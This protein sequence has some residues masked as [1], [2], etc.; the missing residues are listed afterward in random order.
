MDIENNQPTKNAVRPL[1]NPSTLHKMTEDARL[2]YE[3]V[4]ALL[5]EFMQQQVM[6]RYQVTVKSGISAGTLNPWLDGTTK[7]NYANTTKAVRDFLTSMDDKSAVEEAA[8]GEFKKP[9]FIETQISKR[10]L[11]ALAYAQNTPSM[12]SVTIGT[13]MGKTTTAKHFCSTRAN[14]LYVPISPDTCAAYALRRELI[15]AAGLH[16]T[17]MKS[18]IKT[19]GEHMSQGDRR[20][21]IIIDEAQYLPE[22]SINS[23][24]YLYDVYGIGLAFIGNQDIGKKLALSSSTQGVGQIQSRFGLRLNML[25]PDQADIDSYLDAW[26]II[27]P[28]MRSIFTVLAGKT[29]AFR[30]VD[31]TLQQAVTQAAG[32]KTPLTA[33]IVRNAWRNRSN[34]T[35]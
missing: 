23:L 15:D 20:S 22:K 13:G 26:Q 14:V 17:R 5:L 27:D 18:M 24:R 34:E 10:I 6:T 16:Q 29:G 9:K 25:K 11:A 30:Q 31:E 32:L 21:L 33:D 28:E 19:L 2:Q 7:G 1:K 4:H 3:E 35:L 12:V 8:Q